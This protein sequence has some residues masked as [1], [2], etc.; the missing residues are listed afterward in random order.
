[1]SVC[2][3]EKGLDPRAGAA[4]RAGSVQMEGELTGRTAGEGQHQ[5]PLQLQV[6]NQKWAEAETQNCPK[7]RAAGGTATNWKLKTGGLKYTRK[8]KLTRHR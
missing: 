3:E 4:G 2:A 5:E 6:N 1:M 7:H 8:G